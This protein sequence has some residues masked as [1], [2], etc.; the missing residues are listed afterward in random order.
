MIQLHGDEDEAYIRELKR[1]TAAPVIKAV[2]VRN[3][4][5]I[6]MAEQL[7]CEYLLLDT[8]TKGQYGGSG[9]GFDWNLIP[10]L[11]KPFFLAGGISLEN[12]HEAQNCR[13]YCLDVSS[14]VE[15]E[16]R[17]DPEKIRRMVEAV[18]RS[19]KQSGG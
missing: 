12:V 2:R 9:R 5:D 4:D 16:G 1:Q 3:G 11:Q 17:K 6:L 10:P 14:A 19:G 15:T 13:P 7:S 18:R 8:Y